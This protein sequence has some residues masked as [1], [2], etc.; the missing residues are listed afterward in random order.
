MKV[1][2]E[3]ERGKE[4]LRVKVKKLEGEVQGLGFERRRERFRRLRKKEIVERDLG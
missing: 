1:E 2:D 3:R 4:N